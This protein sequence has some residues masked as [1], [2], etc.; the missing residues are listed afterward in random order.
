[1]SRDRKPTRPDNNSR[2][3]AE[4]PVNNGGINTNPSSLLSRPAP[5]QPYRP[6][7]TPGNDGAA[8]DGHS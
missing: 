7:A 1:M 3:F 2:P 8:S 4:A 6:A 5:P